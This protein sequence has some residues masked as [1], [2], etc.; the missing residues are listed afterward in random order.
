MAFVVREGE[1]ITTGR[2]HL[3]VMERSVGIRKMEKAI[4]NFN[5][6]IL[7]RTREWQEV[8]DTKSKQ[9]WKRMNTSILKILFWVWEVVHLF[10][11]RTC[12]YTC[13][14]KWVCRCDCGGR[15]WERRQRPYEG[16]NFK[17]RKE[18]NKHE[19]DQR[20][21]LFVGDGLAF[22]LFAVLLDNITV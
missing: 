8:Q 2:R 7:E 3:R 13:K 12:I 5:M 4:D 22:F 21:R 6:W 18:K 9:M 19:H 11:G 1:M 20:V 17:V 14:R 10:L 16:K 15:V